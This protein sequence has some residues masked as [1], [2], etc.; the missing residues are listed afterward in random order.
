MTDR[1]GNIIKRGD[2]IKYWHKIN[3]RSVPEIGEVI[4][5]NTAFQE[6]SINRKEYNGT[7]IS[8]RRASGI[9]K[10]SKGEAVIWKLEQYC[11][12]SEN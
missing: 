9:T 6:V 5:I 4:N 12:D 3:G 2:A 11:M 7:D 8:I 10:I 1:L